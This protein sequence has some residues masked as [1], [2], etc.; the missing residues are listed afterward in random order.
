MKRYNNFQMLNSCRA[1]VPEMYINIKDYKISIMRVVLSLLATF[2]QIY[3]QA[4]AAPISAQ[5]T[6]EDGNPLEFAVITLVGENPTLETKNAVMPPPIM[7]QQNIQFSPFVLP[8]AVGTTV[9]FPNKDNIRHHVYSFSK[10]KRFEL[11]LY[12]EDEEKSVV[13]D[14]EGVVALGCNIHDN[15]LAYI[16]VARSHQFGTT[17]DL[18]SIEIANVNPGVYFV[19]VWHPR[20]SGDE[21]EYK[22]QI[23]VTDQGLDQIQFRI[24]LKRERNRSRSKY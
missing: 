9:S 17:N 22:R 20:M 4:F 5:V 6:D 13:F 10:V 11:E 19:Y 1:K 23:T 3:S 21:E 15:M 8:V 14:K 16:Y 12:G 7:T 24:P 2:L 18:G